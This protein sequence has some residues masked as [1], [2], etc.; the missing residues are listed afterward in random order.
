MSHDASK[1]VMGGTNSSF[2]IADNK[3]GNI[4]AGLAVRLKSDDTLTLTKAEGS[5]LGISLGKDMGGAG[6]TVIC[7][8]G[9]S[10]PVLVAS[11]VTPVLGGQVGISDSTGEAGPV[12]TGYTA[13]NAYFTKI[14]LTA[15]EEDGTM[16]AD[17][18]LVDIVG[19]L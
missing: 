9:V 16:T 18:A 12:A 10:V 4:K 17:C 13:V 7:K 15:I 14:G 2:K 3:K 1:Q 6:H 11:G 5:L 8:A 19:G